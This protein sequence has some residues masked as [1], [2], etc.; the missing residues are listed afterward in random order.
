MFCTPQGH[1][2]LGIFMMMSLNIRYLIT[3]LYI[4][5][6]VDLIARTV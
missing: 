3:I 4:T 5:K 6:Q 1:A 2:Y